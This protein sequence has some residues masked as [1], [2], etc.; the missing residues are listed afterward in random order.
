MQ[1]EKYTIFNE[2]HY[3]FHLHFFL[4]FTFSHFFSLFSQ[5]QF[6]KSNNKTMCKNINTHTREIKKKIHQHFNKKSRLLFFLNRFQFVLL[7]MNFIES[8][9]KIEKKK[10]ITTIK[11]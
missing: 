9:N 2:S 11:K 7:L 6:R 8:I 4:S 1:P 3:E 5:L 10:E